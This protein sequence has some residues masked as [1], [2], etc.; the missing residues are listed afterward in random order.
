MAIEA[1]RIECLVA[2]EGGRMP[3]TFLNH[4]CTFTVPKVAPNSS[5]VRPMLPFIADPYTYHLKNTGRNDLSDIE[6][7]G[8]DP[9]LIV[10]NPDFGKRPTSRASSAGGGMKGASNASEPHAARSDEARILHDSSSTADRDAVDTTSESE[11]D[12][13]EGPKPERQGFEDVSSDV[14]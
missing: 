11:F 9:S 6:T 12:L 8:A 10:P 3:G 1:C 7:F 4:S 14:L 2:F 5:L 13:Y